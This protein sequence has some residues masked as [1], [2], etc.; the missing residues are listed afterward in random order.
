MYVEF[1]Y[2][3][4]LDVLWLFCLMSVWFLDQPEE[5][6]RVEEKFSSWTAILNESTEWSSVNTHVNGGFQE[7]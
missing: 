3:M 2:V 5:P 6:G 7:D 1:L 4:K